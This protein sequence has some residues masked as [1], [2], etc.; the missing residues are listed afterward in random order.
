[1]LKTNSITKSLKNLL[2][3]KNVIERDEMGFDDDSN[4]KNKI[5]KKSLFQNLNRGTSY[6]TPNARQDFTQLKQ[7]FTKIPTF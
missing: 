1:M 3:S 5:D 6:L 4:Y 2:L 7:V